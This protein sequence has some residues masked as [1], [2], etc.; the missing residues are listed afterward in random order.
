MDI[1][2]PFSGPGR[3]MPEKPQGRRTYVRRPLFGIPLLRQLL[4]ADLADDVVQNFLPVNPK[5][6]GELVIENPFRL[7]QN[8]IAPLPA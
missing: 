4:C 2:A 7:L 3:Q 1:M 8:H 5:N 6:K